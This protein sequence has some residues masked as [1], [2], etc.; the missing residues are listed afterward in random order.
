MY[1]TYIRLL[2]KTSII[3]PDNFSTPML[4]NLNFSVEE[5]SHSPSFDSKSNVDC[6]I[7][8]DIALRWIGSLRELEVAEVY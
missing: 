6:G 7:C 8:I 2:N 4:S 3:K 1:V 5:K